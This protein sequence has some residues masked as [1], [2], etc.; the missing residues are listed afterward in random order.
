MSFVKRIFPFLDWFH[1]YGG[2]A[3]RADLIAGVTV[4]LVL[5][6]QSM[7]YAQLAGLPPH[8]GLY[9]AFLPPMVASLF[10]SSRL[11]ATGPVAIVSLM[12]AA[13][14]EPLATAGSEAYVAYALILALVVGLFQLALGVLRLGVVVNFLSHPVVNGFTNAAALIIATSQLA[15]IFGVYIDN[16]PHHYETI[17]RV[18]AAAFHYTH[19]PTFGMAMLSFAVMI[20]LKRINPRIPNV[21]VAVVITTFAAW[22]VGFEHNEKVTVDQLASPSATEHVLAFNEAIA[23]KSLLEEHRKSLQESKSES[24]AGDAAMCASC[25]E[26]REVHHFGRSK[27]PSP[28]GAPEQPMGAAP[29]EP[30]GALP[31]AP[32]IARE[33]NVLLLHDMAGLLNRRTKELKQE[34]ADHRAALREMLFVRAEGPDGQSRFYLR[35]EAPEGVSASGTWRLKV[36]NFALKTDALKMMGGGAVVG[37][38]PKGLPA[39]RVPDV[40]F[41]IALKL[42]TAAIIISLLGFMEAIS[43]AKAIA[44]RT[45]QKLDAN[46]EL[47]GQGLANI[48]GCMGQSYAVSGS[49]SRSAVNLQAGGRTGLSNVFSSGVVVIVLLFFYGGLYHLPQA[50]LAS[51][52]MMAVLGLLNVSG[53]VHAWKTS[54]FDGAVSV[55]TFVATLVFAPHLENGIFLGIALSLG[56]YLYR[57]MRPHVAVLAPHPDGSMRDAGRLDLKR[58]KHIA[59]VSF[60]GPLNFVSTSYLEGEILA[61]VAEQPELRHL[62][63]AGNGISEVDA[64]GEETLRNLVENLREGGYSVEFSGVPETVLDVLRRSHLYDVIGAEH[65]YGTRAQAIASIYALAHEG[66]EEADCPYRE[67]MP[68]V[69]DLSMHADGSLRDADRHGLPRCRH[70]AALRFDAPLNFANTGFLQQEILHILADRPTLRQIVFVCHGITDIDDTGAQKL[71]EL[72]SKLKSEGFG[73]VFSGVK[74]EVLDVLERNEILKILGQQNLYPTD[75]KAVAAVYARTHTGSSEKDCPLWGLAPHLVELSLHDSNTLR[76]VDQYKLPV[77]PHMAVLRVEGAHVLADS[78]AIQSEFIRWAKARPTVKHV[79]F[80]LGAVDRFESAAALNLRAFIEAVREAGFETS[81]ADVHGRAFEDLG[82]SGI[83]D[84]LGLENFFPSGTQAITAAYAHAHEDEGEEI[85]PLQPILPR[86]VELSLHP[87]GSLRDAHR[88]GLALCER[89]VAV[90]FDGPLDLASIGYFEGSLRRVLTRRAKATHVLIAAHTLTVADA[91]AAEELPSI[92]RR[93][94]ED[95]YAVALSGIKDADLDVLRSAK[96]GETLRA[97]PTFPT[98][99]AAIEA[100]HA[101]TH[102]DASE[103]KCPLREVVKAGS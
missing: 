46:Q 63:V 61:R 53:F 87:D 28:G 12:T 47:V 38:I 1:D 103:E 97:N 37:H 50:V 98:Q 74:E 99:A 70:I 90:R 16:A 84:E 65:F 51:I 42:L 26:P 19:W 71:G 40:D 18:I 69:V 62:V 83:A 68:P 57:S 100:L 55:I 48:I 82:R 20:V 44:A 86:F 32:P 43:I 35:D 27:S 2:A 96:D 67:A 66:S 88:H 36:G 101:E 52:I 39:I 93:L 45:R 11:L 6:P 14:L 80:L 41:G 15:K 29:G 10:G 54:R 91:I 31:V 59:V 21:L 24:A 64:S 75:E 60:E 4:A 58:C 92:L 102:L 9:A 78:R 79:I 33:G 85:C 8:Y 5:V 3:L 89:I 25:H 81:F 72:V 13:T 7:A 23:T 73:I 95:G 49:F 30:A 17:G 22:I 77:C 34:I 94:R 76:E 56:A